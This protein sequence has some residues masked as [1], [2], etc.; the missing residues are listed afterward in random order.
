MKLLLLMAPA[1]IF[2]ILYVS[3]MFGSTEER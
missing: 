1:T 2:L 3:I